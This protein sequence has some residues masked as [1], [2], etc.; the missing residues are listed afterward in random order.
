MSP[1][2][3]TEP[4]VE[5]PVVL[6]A[7]QP[8]LDARDEVAGHELLY[9]REDGTGW[10]IEDESKATAHVVVSAFSDLASSRSPTVRARGSTCRGPS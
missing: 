4:P 10:P 9:R 1:V 2:P 8:I 3:I 5:A 7:R 6:L